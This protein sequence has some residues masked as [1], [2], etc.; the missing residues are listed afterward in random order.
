[1]D[2]PVVAT[3]RGNATADRTGGVIVSPGGLQEAAG[4]LTGMFSGT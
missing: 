2:P 1:M 3:A 4:K